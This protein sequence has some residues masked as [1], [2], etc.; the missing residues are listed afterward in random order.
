[1]HSKILSQGDSTIHKN[2]PALQI[3]TNNRFIYIDIS[4]VG[5]TLKSSRILQICDGVLG[6]I[7]I[8]GK[9]FMACNDFPSITT[10]NDS[11][12][13]RICVIPHIATFVDSGTAEDPVHNIYHKDLD[14]FNKIRQTSW[15]GAY[16]GI[17]VHY[18]EKYLKYDLIKPEI[19][20]SATRKFMEINDPFNAFAN[21]SLVVEAGAGPIRMSDVVLK[22]KECKRTS[23]M[24]DIKKAALLERMKLIAAKGSTDVEFKGVRFK[25]DHE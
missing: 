22:Y 1:M 12:A 14:L 10:T 2:N 18:F 8:M 17:L 21:D 11:I 7:K 23:G 15:R 20:K 16:L 13:R 25:K 9:L 4:D 19:I 5:D 24:L 3:L 6:N